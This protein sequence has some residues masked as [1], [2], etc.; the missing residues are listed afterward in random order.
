MNKTVLIFDD[1]PDISELC[2]ILLSRKGYTVQTCHDCV[3]AVSIVNNV[4]PDVILM[5]N[6]IPGQGGIL[7]TQSIKNNQQLKHIP[8][9]FF[10]ANT[11]IE[12]LAEEATANCFLKKPFNITE[13]ESLVT[14]LTSA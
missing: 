9:I 7:A 14:R 10:T 6:S 2:K 11:N 13:L 12:K 5:D 4:Q 1:D 3:D 8:V